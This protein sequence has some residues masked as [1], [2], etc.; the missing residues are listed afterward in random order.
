[1]SI[2]QT[3]SF[4][5]CPGEGKTRNPGNEVD[6]QTLVTL[7]TKARFSNRIVWIQET[8]VFKSEKIFLCVTQDATLVYR[9]FFW[10]EIYPREGTAWNN[11][12]TEIFA[13]KKANKQKQ[14]R[15]KTKSYHMTKYSKM[16]ETQEK[17]VGVDGLGCIYWLL[18][19]TLLL[20]IDPIQ[21]K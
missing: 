8:G 21:E 5:G 1:M 18:L 12:L 15:D 19:T 11:K 2:K 20:I 3:T 16:I 13:L 6:K 10:Q 9:A 7:Q 4:P 17:Q 14:T